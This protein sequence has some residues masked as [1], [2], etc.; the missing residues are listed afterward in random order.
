MKKRCVREPLHARADEQSLWSAS[1]CRNAT[2]DR[3]IADSPAN[4][5]CGPRAADVV[6]CIAGLGPTCRKPTPALTS[7]TPPALAVP[8]IPRMHNTPATA[9]MRSG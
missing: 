4:G 9:R 6:V 5:K 8:A 3:E 2:G 7:N 1:R